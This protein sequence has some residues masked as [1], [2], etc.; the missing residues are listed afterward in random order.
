[1][2]ALFQVAAFYTFFIYNKFLLEML[3]PWFKLKV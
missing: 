3:Q 2:F 1:L